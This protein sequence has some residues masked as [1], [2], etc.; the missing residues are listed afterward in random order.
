M[1]PVISGEVGAGGRCK[2]CS[3]TLSESLRC[4]QCGAVY[5]DKNRCPHCRSV[6]DVEPAEPLRFRCRICGGPRVP[7]DDHEVVRTGREVPVLKQAKK[8]HA[9]RAAWAVGAGVVGGFGVLSLLATL[10]VIAFGVGAI[11]SVLLLAANAVPFLA[12]ALAWK[13][14]KKQ[15]K[16]RD[17]LM[18]DAWSLVASDVLAHAGNE[19]AAEDLAK[20]MRVEVDRAEL[21]LAHLSAHD[22][23]HARVTEEGDIAYSVGRSKLRI[24][25]PVEDPPVD[26]LEDQ[27]EPEALVQAR[28]PKPEP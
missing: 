2:V 9:I 15:G 21:I 25:S 17:Q 8:A 27:D 28:A 7:V 22:Y 11:A 19:L 20:I 23:V 16:L 24:E 26:E 18:D 6:A 10:L 5:G 1:N 12:A 4:E 13:K 14:A 3:G